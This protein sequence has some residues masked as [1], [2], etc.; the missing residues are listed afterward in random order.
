MGRG[1]DSNTA[2]QNSISGKLVSLD[3]VSQ[4]WPELTSTIRK[5]GPDR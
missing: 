3:L 5:N 1:P 2:Y 4:S